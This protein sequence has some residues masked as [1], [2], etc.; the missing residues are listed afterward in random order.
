MHWPR[1]SLKYVSHALRTWTHSSFSRGLV[2]SASRL[3][4]IEVLGNTYLSDNTTNI[5]PSIISKVPERLYSR[6]GHPIHILK[7]LIESHFNQHGG[8]GAFECP[9]ADTFSPLVTPKQNFDDLSF[10][11]DHP[12]RSLQDSYYVN[13]DLLLRTHT[14]AHEV[15]LFAGGYKNWLLTA[16]VYRRDEIDASHYPVF[17]Q[18]EGASLFST[19]PSGINTLQDNIEYTR[20]ATD[21]R[22]L[23]IEDLTVIDKENPYQSCHDPKQVDLVIESLK[24]SINGLLLKLFRDAVG[25]S[26]GVP[27]RVRWIPAYFPFTSPSYEVEVFFNGKWLEILGCGVVQ[28][29]TLQHA[30]QCKMS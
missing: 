5:T 24:L 30:S 26:R 22:D 18:M 11:P 21:Q 25:V 9:S 8:A 15:E 17:H 3:S 20:Y 16:D 19:S 7:S 29:A 27:L 2:S 23:E 4:S 28:Q 10:P 12:G 14:S 1:R 13:R 6:P